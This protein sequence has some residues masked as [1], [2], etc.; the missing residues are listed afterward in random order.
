MDMIQAVVPVVEQRDALAIAAE[1][2]VALGGLAV[3]VLGVVLVLTLLELRS[4]VREVRA[5]IRD[6]FRPVSD[7]AG[8]IADN[9][10]FITDRLRTD[11]RHLTDSVRSLSE[12]LQQASDHMEVRIEEFNAL[13]E[14][15]QGEAEE[16]FLDTAA[17]VHGLRE[18][19]RSITS[20]RSDLED[21]AEVP[22]QRMGETSAG[23]P[24][25][26]VAV[27]PRST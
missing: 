2:A 19:A 9:V 20:P 4:T 21:P 25:V 27:R 12:R 1:V 22:Y 8:A 17:T 10:E 3:V 26:D 13:M 18:G 11:V 5:G 6:H 23:D 24:D 16:I 14:T 7:R 15:V